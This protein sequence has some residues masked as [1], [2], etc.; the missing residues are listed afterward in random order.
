[1]KYKTKQDVINAAHARGSKSTQ[2]R[3]AVKYLITHPK[4]NNNNGGYAPA[5]VDRDTA[6]LKTYQSRELI[7]EDILIAIARGCAASAK[8]S[9]R[10]YIRSR[11]ADWIAHVPSTSGT[12]QYSRSS[13]HYPLHY[14][15][16]GVVARPLPGGSVAVDVYD[17]R[18]VVRNTVVVAGRNIPRLTTNGLLS[19]DVYAVQISRNRVARYNAD[20]N[21]IGYAIRTDYGWEHGR[22]IEDCQ[23]ETA[24]K[25]EVAAR[26]AAEKIKTAKQQRA[27]RLILRLCHNMILHYDDARAVG[28]CRQGIDDWRQINRVEA[29]SVPV[30][31]IPATADNRWRRVAEYRAAKIA[32]EIISA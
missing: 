2:Y 27:S 18:G 3:S 22:T 5:A 25:Q 13:R 6:A 32:E 11:H 8:K 28:Y 10:L 16:P 9:E 7:N 19:T 29:L 30:N 17:Y 12:V 4:S 21:I 26:E 20:S 23:R 31:R 15:N 24:H 1:M 14:I